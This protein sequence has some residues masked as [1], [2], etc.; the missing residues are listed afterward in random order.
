[1]RPRNPCGQNAI[2]NHLDDVRGILISFYFLNIF[3]LDGRNGFVG[4]VD[5]RLGL[6]QINLRQGLFLADALGVGLAGRLVLGD[7]V[8]LSLRFRTRIEVL[9]LR[10]RLRFERIDAARTRTRTRARTH[11]SGSCPILYEQLL[12]NVSR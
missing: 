6:G 7:L 9:S 11:T 3:G 8:A 12:G 4:L 1:M 2:K 5:E 10:L